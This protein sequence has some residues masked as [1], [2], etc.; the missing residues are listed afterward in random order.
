MQTLSET[1]FFHV[2]VYLSRSPP[3][4]RDFHDQLAHWFLVL[5]SV[6]FSDEPK[7]THEPIEGHLGCFLV[8]E[9]MYTPVNIRVQVSMD[10]SQ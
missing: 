1:D 8:L 3:P 9:I 2:T 5:N 7:F 4:P 6:P 10:V